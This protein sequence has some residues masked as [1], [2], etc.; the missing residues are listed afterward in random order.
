MA[1]RNQNKEERIWVENV[2]DYA[3]E[4]ELNNFYPS[5]FLNKGFQIHHVLGRS[6]KHNKVHIGYWFILP[7][8]YGLHDVS[9]NHKLNVTH[10]KHAFTD[11]FGFQR[12]IFKT[13]VLLMHTLGYPIPPYD[14]LQ[15]IASTRA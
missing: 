15:S 12:D 8:P 13:M 10:H 4:H 5:N 9:S 11:R 14:V 3:N 2:A 7:V 6:A 1:N